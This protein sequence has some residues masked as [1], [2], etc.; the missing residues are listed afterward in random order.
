MRINVIVFLSILL[1][2]VG[3]YFLSQF[4]PQQLD[5]FEKMDVKQQVLWVQD[6][7]EEKNICDEYLSIRNL[8]SSAG[9]FN[10]CVKVKSTNNPQ[11]EKMN[12][13]AFR[14]SENGRVQI[15]KDIDYPY[16]VIPSE[17]QCRTIFARRFTSLFGK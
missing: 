14:C 15:M 17:L 16:G 3:S 10:N 8:C 7:C 11:I 13:S 4:T 5:F 1:Y 9:D 12:R 2:I 6:T